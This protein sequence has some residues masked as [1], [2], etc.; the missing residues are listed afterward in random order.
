MI[1]HALL[2]PNA[3]A[4]ST[5]RT[6]WALNTQPL[7]SHPDNAPETRPSFLSPA[8]CYPAAMTLP[9]LTLVAAFDRGRAIGR[10]N[11]LPW[12]L[13]DDLQRFKQNTLGKPVL[14]G[15]KTAESLRR[16]LPGRQNLVLSTK[17]VA[18]FTGMQCFSSLDDACAATG[19]ATEIMVIGGEAIYALALPH[20][21]RLLLTEVAADTPDADAFFPTFDPAE[22]LLID[23]EEHPADARHA[24]AFAFLEYRRRF[25]GGDGWVPEPG[26]TEKT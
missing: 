18:P 15:R 4:F 17:G 24:H 1:P 25:P 12:R 6:S 21:Q 19:G 22:W 23:R 16:A 2:A 14:M 9:T 5:D 13:P 26:S 11:D 3:P 8:L 10:Q 7:H 20:A